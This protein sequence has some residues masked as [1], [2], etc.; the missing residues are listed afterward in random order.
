MAL[1]LQLGLAA[2]LEIPL[3]LA[4]GGAMRNGTLVYNSARVDQGSAAR[5]DQCVNSDGDSV[6]CCEWQVEA[7]VNGYL[8]VAF[9]A[10]LWSMFLV[11]QI[12]MFTV[13]GTIAQWYFQPTSATDEQGPNRSRTLTSLRFALGPSLGSLCAGSAVLTLVSIVRRML[14]KLRRD[15]TTNLFAACLAAC[16]SL[17]L[18]LVEF[19][20]QFATVR[21][22]ITG[23][24]FFTAGRNVVA[25]LKR[26]LM[27]AFGV[28]WLPPLVLQSSS[29]LLAVAWG[30]LAYK[31]SSATTW[32][33]MAG[34]SPE[35]VYSMTLLTAVLAF[36]AGWAVLSFLASLLLNVIDAL[37][38]CFAMDRELGQVSGGD[39][40]THGS[41]EGTKHFQGGRTGEGEI[42]GG[43]G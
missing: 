35:Q 22:A 30:F 36:L 32:S 12:K 20:T 25:L 38:V 28:W 6:N 16:L 5:A 40:V 18:S 43:G 26:N 15:G 13:A 2:V 3:L 31:I 7:W 27:D 10:M 33:R 9:I 1:G 8:V 34:W 11:F 39:E 24:A 21:A 37:F 17:L 29:F 42:L 14:Q 4:V 19:V 41:E 23:E